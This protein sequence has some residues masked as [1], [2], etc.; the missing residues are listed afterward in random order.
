MGLTCDIFCCIS[1]RNR[2]ELQLKMCCKND[3]ENWTKDFFDESFYMPAI[4]KPKIAR[5]SSPRRYMV[6]TFRS[7]PPNTQYSFIKTDPQLNI[8]SRRSSSSK[9]ILLRH[10]NLAMSPSNITK[11][12]QLFYFILPSKFISAGVI[13]PSTNTA[14][15]QW[16]VIP[17]EIHVFLFVSQVFFMQVNSL[18]SHLHF[19]W[20]LVDKASHPFG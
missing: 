4:C 14:P 8:S 3:F 11:N 13:T 18:F 17:S 19:S 20:Q 1:Y 10:D 6:L 5:E 12:Q 16:P 2:E 9:T 7:Y 15:W